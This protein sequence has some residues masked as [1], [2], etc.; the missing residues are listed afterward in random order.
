M[1]TTTTAPAALH[2]GDR[3]EADATR[4]TLRDACAATVLH[5]L[6][7]EQVAEIINR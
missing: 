2:S 1:T 6:S 4:E 7:P 5:G 3:A